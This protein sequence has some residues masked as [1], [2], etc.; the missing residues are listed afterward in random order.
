MREIGILIRGP[1]AVIHM[2]SGLKFRKRQALVQ[3]LLFIDKLIN[4]AVDDNTPVQLRL[5]I[6]GRRVAPI[7]VVQLSVRA[8]Y[9]SGVSFRPVNLPQIVEKDFTYGF[10]LCLQ[11]IEIDIFIA[12]VG[13]QTDEIAL[14]G[15]DIGNF[16]LF[17]ESFDCRIILP[18]FLAGLDG[19]ADETVLHQSRN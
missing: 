19:N 16:V 2:A 11:A 7:A 8:L 17:E 18:F 12:I 10:R 6:I 14:V 4:K 13:A 3:N 5:G 15:D 1:A 9:H